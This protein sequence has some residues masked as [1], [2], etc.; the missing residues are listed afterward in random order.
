[1][2]SVDTPLTLLVTSRAGDEWPIST[3]NKG[4]IIEFIKLDIED[5]ASVD[6]VVQHVKQTYGH[7]DVLV[8]NAAKTFEMRGAGEAYGQEVA[9]KSINC[10]GL[11]RCSLIPKRKLC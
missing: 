2:A 3:K 6:S 11:Y 10:S 5:Q 4:T 7:L 9:R 1:M 8:N